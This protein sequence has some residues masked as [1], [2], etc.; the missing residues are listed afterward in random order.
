[1]WLPSFS[2]S[3]QT[4]AK[5]N[6]L[7]V[8]L[9]PVCMFL[10]CCDNSVCAFIEMA[11]RCFVSLYWQQ[12]CDC[13]SCDW[14]DQAEGTNAICELPL[15]GV[16]V[17]HP[18]GRRPRADPGHVGEI[19]SVDSSGNA[20]VSQKSR[21]TWKEVWACALRPPPPW[22]RPG[23]AGEWWGAGLIQAL[24]VDMIGVLQ[25]QHPEQPRSDIISENESINN[26]SASLFDFHCELCVFQLLWCSLSAIL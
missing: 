8:S 6:M 14:K 21:R 10:E 23:R 20:S 2:Q 11:L 5:F 1:M 26:Q 4:G 3:E 16:W 25:P 12:C 22:A 24:W 9:C 13:T 15:K 18:T 7:E 17:R 19:L